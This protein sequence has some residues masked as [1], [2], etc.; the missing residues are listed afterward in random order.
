[1]G[2][3]QVARN[4]ES[5]TDPFPA[6]VTQR[7]L[8]MEQEYR[9]GTREEFL[10]K[11]KSGEYDNVVGIY[12]SNESTSVTGPFNKELVGALPRSLKYIAHN[13]AGY[14]NIDVSACTEK[15]I[16]ISSTPI[17][18]NDSTADSMSSRTRFPQPL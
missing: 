1:M 2:G 17:A 14:D 8:T 11:C 3:S 10:E 12:R 5:E 18:V 15:G 7:M 6:I 16:Q 13:G 4:I 9:S